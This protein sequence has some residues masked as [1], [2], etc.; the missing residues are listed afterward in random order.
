MSASPLPD[1][2][3]WIRGLRIVD[4]S[5]PRHR[6]WGPSPLFLLFN[7]R[8]APPHKYGGTVGTCV[9]LVTPS[10]HLADRRGCLSV[11]VKRIGAPPKTFA[12]TGYNIMCRPLR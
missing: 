8:T 9:G 12:R 1:V 4:I 7:T 3:G 10:C 2:V 5:R 6:M 11:V